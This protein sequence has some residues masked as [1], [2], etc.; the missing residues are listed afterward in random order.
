[1]ELALTLPI[2]AALAL[3]IVQVALVARDAVLVEHAA[4]AAAREAAVDARPHEVRRAALRDAPALKPD[5]LSTETSY[6][7]GSPDT[8]IVRVR[9][10]SPTY[11]PV[12]GPLLPDVEIATKAAISTEN[13]HGTR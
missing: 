1:M 7:G 10:R 2:L 8:V 11:V 3:V 13:G 5:R 12:V 6:G 9:Y 4:R